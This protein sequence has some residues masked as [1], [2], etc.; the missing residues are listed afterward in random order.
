[1]SPKKDYALV[2]VYGGGRCSIQKHVLSV[3]DL[4]YLPGLKG[5]SS[6]SFTHICTLGCMLELILKYVL[7]PRPN[8]SC[9]L[10]PA[11][12]KQEIREHRGLGVKRKCW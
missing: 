12:V 3:R 4:S 6:S 10:K 1:M 5:R 11:D 2:A 7:E 9:F 8:T